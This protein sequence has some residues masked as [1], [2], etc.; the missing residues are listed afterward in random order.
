MI[1]VLTGLILFLFFFGCG[2][3]PEE[4]MAQQSKLAIFHSNDIM[5]YLTPCG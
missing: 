3:T 4:L 2:S 1:K 5:G